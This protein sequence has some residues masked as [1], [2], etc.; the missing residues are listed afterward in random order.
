MQAAGASSS[1]TIPEQDNNLASPVPAVSNNVPG[2]KYKYPQ[3]APTPPGVD[4]TEWNKIYTAA[5][6]R[7]YNRHHKSAIESKKYRERGETYQLALKMLEE[8]REKA[9][10]VAEGGL[11]TP[12]STQKAKAP[13][14][15][16]KSD[17]PA[18]I[19][20]ETSTAS[21]DASPGGDKMTMGIAEKI[22]SEGRARKT[23]SVAP[24]DHGTP[25]PSSAPKMSSPAPPP[26][27]MEKPAPKKRGTATTV[28]KPG[29]K[30]K[31]RGGK[32]HPAPSI[33]SG[34]LIYFIGKSG[35]PSS[36]GPRRPASRGN[37]ST[38]SSSDDQRY[39]ICKGRDDHRLMVECEAEDCDEW[40][41]CSCL[42]MDEDDV[43]RLLDRFIC[44]KC[45]TDKLF[46]TWRRVCRYS[47]V[48]KEL[49]IVTC[50]N[51]ARVGDDE[52]PSEGP[53]S[54]YCSE[55][56]KI[57]FMQY[58]L[59][60]VRDDDKPSMGGA[61]NRAEVSFLIKDKNIAQIHAL[62]QKPR[63]PKKEGA[64]PSKSNS[65]NG[66]LRKANFYRPSSWT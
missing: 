47:N 51:P 37:E 20:K 12:K 49:G 50:R 57:K 53:P 58:L 56:C 3:A 8:K 2:F 7:N 38:G 42:G 26:A 65:H 59:N 41:H 6:S 36:A 32:F 48:G 63:L 28:K 40:Y 9:K 10:K 23:S 16:K 33:S 55:E 31:N 1:A 44:P 14:T 46:T 4:D 18:T 52:K 45:K 13:A 24:S 54:K 29:P 21:R 15:A 64:D 60:K 30:P 34:L 43:N 66:Q 22:K 17:F 27:K 11:S 62:G 19:K 39:C 5:D 61:L 25:G 35:T